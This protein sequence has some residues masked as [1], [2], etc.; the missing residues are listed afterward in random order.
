MLSW[1]FGPGPG[2]LDWYP[3]AC[4]GFLQR[5]WEKPI[6]EGV[7]TCLDPRD[8]VFAHSM[9]GVDCAREVGAAR[10]ALFLLDQGGDDAG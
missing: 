6:W 8:S 7:L 10:R 3:M 4:A 2:V 1:I 9:R 5:L